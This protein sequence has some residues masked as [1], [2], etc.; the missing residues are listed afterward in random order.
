MIKILWFV[1]T[2][3]ILLTALAVIF[4][5][6]PEAPEQL[7]DVLDFLE[8]MFTYFNFFVPFNDIFN[9]LSIILTF[10]VGLLLFKVFNWIWKK[11]IISS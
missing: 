1:S 3:F 10:E 4:P 5:S 11:V 7:Q 8:P 9:A 6:V 2:V